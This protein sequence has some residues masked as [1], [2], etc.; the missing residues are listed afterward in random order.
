MDISF[1]AW[2]WSG[3]S[4]LT[5]D[6]VTEGLETAVCRFSCPAVDALGEVA[7]FPNRERSV[8]LCAAVWLGRRNNSG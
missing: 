6:G 1:P 8:S 7:G 2:W 3:V 4:G 5:T